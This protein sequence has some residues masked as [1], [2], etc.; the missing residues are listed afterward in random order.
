M[1]PQISPR[2]SLSGI[3]FCVVVACASNSEAG[4]VYT[5]GGTLDIPFALGTGISNTDFYMAEDQAT[6]ITLALR[7]RER[8]QNNVSYVGNTYVV[9]SGF[10]PEAQGSTTMSPYAWWNFDVAVYGGGVGI[11]NS[12]I[13]FSMDFNP[14]VGSDAGTTVDIPMNFVP[15]VPAL[16]PY[17]ASENLGFDYW[18]TQFGQ[19][20]DPNELGHYTI[21]LGVQVTTG[22]FAGTVVF[23]QIHVQVVPAPAVVAAFAGLPIAARR[24]RR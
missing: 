24:R 18:S 5:A 21:S 16:G 20:F 15:G 10:S 2:V 13:V 12:F 11:S 17:L 1:L 3:A 22:E 14:A 23:S 6:G 19:S 7:A 4:V 9:Q 8:W